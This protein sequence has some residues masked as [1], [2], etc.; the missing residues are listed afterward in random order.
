MLYCQP[1]LHLPPGEID[2]GQTNNNKIYEKNYL[3][4]GFINTK[5]LEYN[6]FVTHMVAKIAP[7]MTEFHPNRSTQKCNVT[8]IYPQPLEVFI[9]GVEFSHLFCYSNKRGWGRTL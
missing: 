3:Q 6:Y 8:M 9:T 2:C 7:L 1:Y 5:Q 4:F